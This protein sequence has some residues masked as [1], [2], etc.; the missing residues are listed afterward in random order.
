MEITKLSKVDQENWKNIFAKCHE[1]AEF[2]K[3]LIANPVKVLEKLAGKKLNM[4]GYKFIV[5]DQSDASTIHINIPENEN[6]DD[7]QLTEEQLEFV[8]GGS[9]NVSF[10]FNFF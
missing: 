10:M 6:A 4:G 2:K 7:L 5:T 9:C 3:E 8:A 1:D